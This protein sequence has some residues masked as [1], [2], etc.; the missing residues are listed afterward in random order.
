MD[1]RATGAMV[2]GCGRR[3]TAG[4]FVVPAVRP[5]ARVTVRVDSSDDC[6]ETVWMSLTADEALRLAGVLVAQA[7]AI[8][9]H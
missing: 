3:V 5:I 9:E 2:T 4:H 1:D 7:R 8:V 6:C